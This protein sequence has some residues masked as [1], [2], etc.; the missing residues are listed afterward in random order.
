MGL[1]EPVPGVETRR[2]LVALEVGQRDARVL[3]LERPL[4]DGAQQRETDPVPVVAG[5]DVELPQHEG[6]VLRAERRHADDLVTLDGHEG[7]ALADRVGDDVA[8]PPLREAHGDVLGT[9]DGFVGREPRAVADGQDARQVVADG[10]ADDDS[11]P[12]AASVGIPGSVGAGS[13]P[14]A[15][16]GV[17]GRA[18][19]GVL[20]LV[21]AVR[22]DHRLTTRIVAGVVVADDD[23]G[24]RARQPVGQ[25]VV[26]AGGGELRRERLADD[27]VAVGH[28]GLEHLGATQD[29]QADAVADVQA[30]VATGL[31]D[32]ADE[33]A[34]QA[35]GGQLGRHR[36]VEDDEAARR[37]HRRGTGVGGVAGDDGLEGVLPLDERETTGRDGAV[38]VDA[39][40]RP[41]CCP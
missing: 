5:Q 19:V 10:T 29:R 31:L 30:G 35:L 33:V 7:A 8:R 6:V 38:G 23:V 18:H 15:L 37:Q 1:G 36:R 3:A 40:S 41:T 26:A 32:G 11:V 16:P 22:G 28:R 27:E 9:R 4:D 39:S 20:Q 12:A 21:L 13:V 34:G 24:R 25:R 17:G 14:R 2:L